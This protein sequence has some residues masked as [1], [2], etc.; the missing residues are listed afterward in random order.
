MTITMNQ[1]YYRLTPTN[2]LLL[3]SITTLLACGSGPDTKTATAK[4]GTKPIPHMWISDSLGKAE[5]A[6]YLHFDTILSAMI[7]APE[8]DSIFYPV[9]EFLGLIDTIGTLPGI[10][11]LDIYPV[12]LNTGKLSLLF[13]PKDSKYR[14]LASFQLKENGATFD[15]V[16]DSVTP[17]DAASWENNYKITVGTWLN[18]YLDSTDRYN[19]LDCDSGNKA[20]LSNTLHILHKYSDFVELDS[21]VNYQLTTATQHV[22]ISGFKA[23]FSAF[24]KEPKGTQKAY[25]NRLFAILEF[26]VDD[27][28]HNHNVY[29]IDT[30]GR[31]YVGPDP[32]VVASKCQYATTRSSDNG[33][34]CPPSCNP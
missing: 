13:V 11:Y 2:T 15:R 4:A 9:Q 23:F 1:M 12:V 20:N 3:L 17:T 8:T 19:Y 7:N 26:T 28:Q 34:M 31:Q 22:T 25:S 10:A 30:T 24:T 16:G 33:Q 14:T 32:P 6:N 27:P 29:A 18:S 21:E 5:E